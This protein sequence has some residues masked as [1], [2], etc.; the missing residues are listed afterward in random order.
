MGTNGN[1][2][3]AKAKR[4]F[5]DLELCAHYY[6]QEWV[7]KPISEGGL[8][9]L[10]PLCEIPPLKISNNETPSG[11]GLTTFCETWDATNCSISLPSTGLYEAPSSIWW[12]SRKANKVVF[13]SGEEI[14][15]EAMYS[16]FESGRTFWTTLAYNSSNPSEPNKRRFVFPGFLLTRIE[17]SVVVEENQGRLASFSDLPLFA[18]HGIV[19][20][21]DEAIIVAINAVD[22]AKTKTLFEAGLSVYFRMHLNPTPEDLVSSSLKFAE[23]IRQQNLA[24]KES[25]LEFVG[26]V[27]SLQEIK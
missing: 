2:M 10:K 17:G 13:A 9:I 14:V 19:L 27:C 18:A 3:N 16:H 21:Y 15:F 24:S 12:T 5:A 20:A 26:K 11:Q 25:V 6:V 23:V 8:N 22:N 4:Y 7:M 1:A